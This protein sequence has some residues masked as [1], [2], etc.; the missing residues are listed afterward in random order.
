M[1]WP[2]RV[3]CWLGSMVEVPIMMSPAGPRI[4]ELPAT[5]RGVGV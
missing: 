5:R 3:A 4:M 1:M 2:D